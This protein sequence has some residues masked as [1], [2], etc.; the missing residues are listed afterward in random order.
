MPEAAARIGERYD[1]EKSDGSGQ[2][3]E[4]C[5][6]SRRFGDGLDA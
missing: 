4:F 6:T 2:E 5:G 1:Q 3:A